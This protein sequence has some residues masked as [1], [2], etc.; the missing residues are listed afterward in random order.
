[1]KKIDLFLNNQEPEPSSYLTER[2]RKTNMYYP[3]FT[4]KT[5]SPSKVSDDTL[6]KSN[7][8]KIV[9]L[10]DVVMRKL[11]RMLCKYSK[12]VGI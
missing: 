9:I 1:M 4:L 2:F 7:Y 10:R 11:I 8:I 5:T 3:T 12:P 6:S